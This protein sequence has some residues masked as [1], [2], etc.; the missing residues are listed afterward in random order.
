MTELKKPNNR[1]VD[2]DGQRLVWIWVGF[3]WMT[4]LW[5]PLSGASPDATLI[6]WGL[7]EASGA[8]AL[9]SYSFVHFR[10]EHLA[11]NT[12]LCLFAVQFWLQH[13]SRFAMVTLLVFSTIAGGLAHSWFSSQ[14][15]FLLHGASAA[16]AALLGAGA[17]SQVW[18]GRWTRAVLPALV[19]L[20]VWMG[21][22]SGSSWAAHNGGLLV[23]FCYGAL[24]TLKPPVQ[25]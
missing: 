13:Y 25:V 14:S 17:F 24:R 21:S 3:N 2:R 20:V 12:V 16:T 1:I 15:A 9:I 8:Y 7:S 23:G 5:I 11:I 22:G 4:F 18:G 19:F 6:R 10:I